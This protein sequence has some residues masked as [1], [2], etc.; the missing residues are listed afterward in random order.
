MNQA[1]QQQ[2]AKP[3]EQAQLVTLLGLNLVDAFRLVETEEGVFELHVLDTKGNAL[4]LATKRA[5][6]EAR[7]FKRAEA[8]FGF[9][10]GH[11]IRPVPPQIT[12]LLR[13]AN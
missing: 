4:V 12:V 9:I 1:E 8:A 10:K 7:Q 6:T 2:Q 3:I 11:W 5:S 13:A